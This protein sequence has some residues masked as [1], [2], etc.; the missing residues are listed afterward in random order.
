MS[1]QNNILIFG[2]GPLQSSIIQRSV[3]KGNFT[4]VIDPDPNAMARNLADRFLVVPGNDFDKTCE[5]IV[6]YGINGI[7][8][9]ATDKPLRMMARIAEKFNLPFYSISTA[10]KC[11]DKYKMKAVFEAHKIPCA[12]G[13]LIQNSSEIHSFPCIIKPVDNSGSR[14]VFYVENTSMADQLLLESHQ[15]SSSDQILCEEYIDGKEYSVESIHDSF[16]SK[17]VQITEKITSTF[18][19][20][21]EMGHIAPAGVS[22]EIAAEICA[23]IDRIAKAFCFEN[24]AAHTEIK[25]KDQNIT[26]I[27]TSP[28]LG[29]DKITSSLVPLSTGNNIEDFVLDLSIG[30]KPDVRNNTPLHAGIYY[31]KLP[32]GVISSVGSL[33]E[34]RDLNGVVEL[35]FSL[36]IG[37]KVPAI[38]NSLD[39]YGY[40]VLQA[41]SRDKLDK[42]ERE[43]RCSLREKIIVS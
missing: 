16:G 38:R 30:I 4:L 2:A 41:V 22:E 27:E 15:H 31:I 3:D 33:D 10:E 17:V 35:D 20:N 36:K 37:D 19:S 5:I 29:G 26:V 14:G 40:F 43:V 24:C 8:T 39:R 11:T 1:S 28:R 13:Y 34:I 21:V 32:D 18:P 23:L 42:L 6:Q 12:N 9:A 7:A 25:I